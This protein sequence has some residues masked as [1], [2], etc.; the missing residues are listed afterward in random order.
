MRPRSQ[1]GTG[2]AKTLDATPGAG[3]LSRQLL[4]TPL[5]ALPQ[6]QGVTA[7]AAFV[8]RGFHVPL[9]TSLVFYSLSGLGDLMAHLGPLPRLGRQLSDVFSFYARR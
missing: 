9:L 3:T 5:S 1:P 4:M 6:T 7:T 8:R 2:L